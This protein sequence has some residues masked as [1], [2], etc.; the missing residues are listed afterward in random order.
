T[1]LFHQLVEDDISV[2]A[3]LRYLL[4]GGEVLSVRQ[5]RRALQH[6]GSCRL[7]NAYGPTEATTF[8]SCHPVR[9]QDANGRIPIGRPISNTQVYVLDPRFEPAPV[10][11]PGELYV[12]GAGLA[13]GYL[14]RPGLTAERFVPHP[15]A[16]GERLY[17]TGDLVCWRPD[18]AL[19][20]LGRLDTQV[21]IR[22]F[23]IEPGE[24]EA[25]LLAHPGIDQ[26]AVVVREDAGDRRLVAYLVG[27]AAAG[28]T[29]LRRHLQRS[30]PDYMIPAALV[31]LD[32]LPLTSN[33]KLDRNALPAPEAH[34]RQA[35][36]AP[37]NA[38][39][40]ALAGILAGV[41]GLDRVGIDDNF[42]E[43]GGDS[44]LATRAA[45]RV[46]HELGAELPLRTLFE[47][48]TVARLADCLRMTP[49]A[50]GPALAKVGRDQPLALSHAQ[51]RLWFLEQLGAVGGS[52]NIGLAVRLA[53]RLEAAA[54]A[55]ALSG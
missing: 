3:P 20:F 38:A 42:F 12:G 5:V 26:A 31:A 50:F 40:Q 44:I 35:Y 14:G 18:G 34:S 19:D 37:R 24:I 30:L 1:G 15:F 51:E 46:Q 33:G 13:R 54:T 48:P 45:A 53:A 28:A 16:I 27:E 11:V 10:G 49:A 21:K 17:R 36:L 23:R 41:L 52:Y 4:T 43:L 39:E 2:L 29:E 55:A 25:A 6:L 7:I 22:G 8:S 47:A 9:A 32:Q